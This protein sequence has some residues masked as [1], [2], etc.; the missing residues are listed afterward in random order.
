MADSITKNG[1]VH[2]R[3]AARAREMS[4][5]FQLM[6]WTNDAEMEALVTRLADLAV[7]D[8]KQNKDTIQVGDAL[9]EIMN[10][11]RADALAA[12]KSD[13]TAALEL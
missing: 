11:T 13:R 3:T 10:L 9:E 7:S 1:Y 12:G 5:W 8:P 6:N 4:E 2:G